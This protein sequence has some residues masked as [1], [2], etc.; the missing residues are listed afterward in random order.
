L[1]GSGEP[2]EPC[3]ARAD[4]PRWHRDAKRLRARGKRLDVDR[5]AAEHLGEVLVVISQRRRVAPVLGG[6]QVVG[7]LEG[8][9]HQSSTYL[10]NPSCNPPSTGITC[11][12][13]RDSR[14]ETSTRIAS[15]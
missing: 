4:A 10:R 13:V 7:D 3:A 15:A 9:D 12:V 1:A 8:S 14:S 5:A 2:G 11:P 6:N